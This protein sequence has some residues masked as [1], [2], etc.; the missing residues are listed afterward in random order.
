[1]DS[2]KKEAKERWRTDRGRKE[3]KELVQQR[4]IPFFSRHFSSSSFAFVVVF[5]LPR[6][7]KNP[8]ATGTLE[9]VGKV[10]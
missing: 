5:L 4:R 10:A 1:M 6:R 2:K 9:P 8:Y 3:R 7:E